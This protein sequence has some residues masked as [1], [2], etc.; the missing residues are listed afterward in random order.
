MAPFALVTG[1]ADRIGKGLALALAESGYDIFLHYNSSTEKAENTQQLIEKTGR[2]CILKQAD[3]RNEAEV[4]SLISDCVKEGSVEVLINNAS[5][6]IE[7]NIET[8]GSALLEELFATNFKA[9]YTLT[10]QFVKHCGEGLII[11]LLDTKINQNQTGHLDY[12]LTK[13][14]LEAFTKLS[15]VQLAPEI[16]VNG[17]APGLILPPEDKSDDYL[18]QRAKNIPLKKTGSVEQLARAMKFLIESP[19]VTGEIIYVDGGEHL[20]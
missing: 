6:F 15:A 19:F 20:D 9:P 11:N 10:K 7:S 2:K 12:L 17:I 1:A 13:K 8:E 14:A 4:H 16:R 3:F 5:V 18:Q